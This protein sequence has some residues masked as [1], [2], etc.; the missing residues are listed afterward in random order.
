MEI[1]ILN[2]HCNL[3]FG[4]YSNKN[5]SMVA[6]EYSTGTPYKLITG[7][8]LVRLKDSSHVAIRDSKYLIDDLINS[9]IICSKY[10]N[11]IEE[12]G[13]KLLVYKLTDNCI[14]NM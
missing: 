12:N 9:N 7:N 1:D 11:E 3:S 6:C 2:N 10:V 8:T 4:R 13:N 14:N 5:T